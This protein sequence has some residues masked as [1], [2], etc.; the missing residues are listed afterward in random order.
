MRNSKP[1]IALPAALFCVSLLPGCAVGPGPDPW[2]K[3]N[4]AFYNFNDKLDRYALKPVSD[5]YVKVTPQVVRTSFSNALDNLLYFNVILNDFLQGKFG[6][7]LSDSGRMAANSTAGLGGLFDIA[8]PLNLSSHDNDFGIT[9]ATWGVKPGPYMVLP[10]MGPTTARDVPGIGVG[11]ACNP[12]TW[13]NPPLAANLSV[14]AL[15]ILDGRSRVENEFKFRNTAAIDPYLFTRDA[16]MQYRD[17]LINDGKPKTGPS[18]YD[19]DFGPATAPAAT[20]ATAPATQP[21][22]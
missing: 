11:I 8:T 16:Y 17:G 19:E 20:A 10:L 1:L 18:I 15:T 4:R 22:K 5:A 12:M 9:L 7:G 3:T 14:G 13:I 21:G 2:E 6:Q